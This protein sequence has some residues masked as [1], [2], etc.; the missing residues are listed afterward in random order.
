MILANADTL[1]TPDDKWCCMHHVLSL[2]EDFRS[3][4]PLIQSLIEDAGHIYLFLP[5]F[6]C[7]LNSIEML[8]GYSVKA[9]AGL[10][11]C[12]VFDSGTPAQAFPK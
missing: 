1:S 5:R 3:E 11:A 10:S 8:L 2:Q 7:K 4:K 12:Q 6:H 9:T